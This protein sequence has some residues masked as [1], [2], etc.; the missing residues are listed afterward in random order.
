MNVRSGS[1]T[2]ASSSV[3]GGFNDPRTYGGTVSVKF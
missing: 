1:Y 3:T 2:Q